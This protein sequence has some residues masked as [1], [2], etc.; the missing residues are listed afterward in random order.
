MKKRIALLGAGSWGTAL[1]VVLSE[2]GH[3]VVLW[4]HEE[5][6]AHAMRHEHRN[7]TYLPNLKLP[8]KLMIT[9]DLEHAVQDAHVICFVVPTKAIRE[10]AERVVKILEKKPTAMKLPLIM[11]ASKGLEQKTHLRISQIL[12]NVLEDYTKR[13][14]VVL[15]GP[16]H[17][18]EVAERDLTA[19]TAAS[20][21]IEAAE[22]VQ[23]L[24]MN[25]Y[26]R[27][28]TNSDILGVELG[29][30]LKNIIAVCAGALDGLSFG[31]NA[32]AALMTRGLAEITRLGVALGADPLTFSGLSGIGDLIVTCTSVHSRNWQTGY[33]IGKGKDAEDVINHMTMIVEGVATAKVAAEI[34]KGL[35]IEM[36]ITEA[37]NQVVNEHQ[38]IDAVIKQLM[39][40]NAKSEI[41]MGY[42]NKFN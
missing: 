17:A 20:C 6:H 36:P 30:A 39:A 12:N 41:Q 37:V 18:E 19:V 1:S 9:S 32:K 21:D 16:S 14:I 28:Y 42:V 24:F 5:A 29:G 35:G 13:G 8:E 23:S 38:S 2:N 7:R 26:F 11:H 10:V 4:T 40:R 33:Q 15:S 25:D 3:D 34:A 27:V 31:D 22:E